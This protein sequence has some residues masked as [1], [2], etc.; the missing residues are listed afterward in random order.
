MAHDMITDVI[1][2]KYSTFEDFGV[3]FRIQ[4]VFLLPSDL[5]LLSDSFNCMK[6]ASFWPSN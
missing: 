4:F 6:Q 5:D 3:Q 1:S 2:Y